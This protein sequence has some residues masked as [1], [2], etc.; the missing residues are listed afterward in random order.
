MLV[1]V[2]LGYIHIAVDLEQVY[3]KLEILGMKEQKQGNKGTA[4]TREVA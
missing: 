4:E 2:L 3:I 1:I